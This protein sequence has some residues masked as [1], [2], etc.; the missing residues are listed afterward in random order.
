MTLRPPPSNSVS[1]TAEVG[2]MRMGLMPRLVLALVLALTLAACTAPAPEAR[3]PTS[4]PID[5]AR[6]QAAIVPDAPVVPSTLAA[7]AD[8]AAPMCEVAPGL[9]ADPRAVTIAADLCARTGTTVGVEAAQT[10]DGG[11]RGVIH[12]EPA[13]PVGPLRTHLAWVAAALEAHD[14]FLRALE[15]MALAPVRYR[16]KPL[17]IEFFK[18]VGGH[19]PSAYAHDWTIAYNVTGSLNLSADDVRETLFHEIFHLNDEAHGD[20]SVTALS[21]LYDPIV[22]RCGTRMA[23]LAPYAPN[24]TVVRGGTYYAF[25]PGNGRSVREYA[26]ELAVRY[27]REERAAQGGRPERPPF[28]C[29]QP[30]N[31]RAW[32]LLLD[33]FFG[34]LDRTPE[35]PK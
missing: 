19:R 32:R 9:A 10:M 14:D 22:T 30:E 18:S 15:P 35:C 13:F 27:Y 12:I 29:G 34:G 20:W 11:F 26:A 25:Q 33:E 3:P 5:A 8:E 6:T 16:W 23:C 7:T 2:I 31:A 17:A 28:K 1:R 24:R 4:A 21:G